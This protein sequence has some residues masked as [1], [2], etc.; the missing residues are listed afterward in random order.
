MYDTFKHIGLHDTFAYFNIFYIGCLFNKSD[1]RA[2]L[3]LWFCVCVCNVLA[4]RFRC[5]FR[6]GLGLTISHK[7]EEECNWSGAGGGAG[8][9]GK[10]NIKTGI[11]HFCLLYYLSPYFH[12]FFCAEGFGFKREECMTLLLI[13]TYFIFVAYLTKVTSE[14]RCCF[15]FVCGCVMNV[16]IQMTTLQT[17]RER[18]TKKK[19]CQWWTQNILACVPSP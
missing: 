12:L 6:W 5:R 17:R 4:C 9:W 11:I 19:T 1:Q 15:D 10:E 7:A 3:L 2:P 13:S 16:R 18:M 14:R 8:G